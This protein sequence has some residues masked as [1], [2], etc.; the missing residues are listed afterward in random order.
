VSS[1]CISN[2]RFPFSRR[3]FF[4]EVFLFA[5]RI[6]LCANRLMAGAPKKNVRRRIARDVILRAAALDKAVADSEAL[7]CDPADLMLP[8]GVAL[9]EKAKTGD[10]PALKEVFDR[11]DGK[12][13]Q[14]VELGGDGTVDAGLVG[15]MGELL[16]RLP[17][18]LPQAAPNVPKLAHGI[19]I[20]VLPD[21]L[22]DIPAVLNPAVPAVLKIGSQDG[23]K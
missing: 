12:L 8:M 13:V 10:V 6:F 7:A 4:L 23:S 20:D 2:N 18:S 19:Q 11:V 17:M 5:K 22:P 16:R 15:T 9:Y 14:E 1:T 3:K 21:V